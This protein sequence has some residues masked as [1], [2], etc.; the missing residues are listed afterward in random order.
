MAG[1]FYLH[2]RRH[3]YR[4]GYFH[5]RWYLHIHASRPLLNTAFMKDRCYCC[6]L[7]LSANKDANITKL[8]V[9]ATEILDTSAAHFTERSMW[10][11]TREWL[12]T[13]SSGV[14][15]ICFE[16]D[17]WFLFLFLQNRACW[18]SRALHI[19]IRRY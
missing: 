6:Q 19:E 3:M 2:A 5:R 1:R 11:T 14:N 7:Q 9:E 16:A 12:L 17:F 4:H 18:L 15:R 13:L 10:T 8:A